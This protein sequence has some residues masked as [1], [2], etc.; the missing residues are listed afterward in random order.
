MK[1]CNFSGGKRTQLCVQM[2]TIDSACSTLAQTGS[3]KT[4]QC[5]KLSIC[6][7]IKTHNSTGFISKAPEPSGKLLGQVHLYMEVV[8]TCYSDAEIWVEPWTPHLIWQLLLHNSTR[9]SEQAWN[10]KS[11]AVQLQTSHRPLCMDG[12]ITFTHLK[13]PACTQD[14]SHGNKLLWRTNLQ[15]H[16]IYCCS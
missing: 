15:S 6:I 11:H 8:C 16:D 10:I 14:T 5:Q 4:F 3:R 9:V 12:Q 13:A 1:P 7:Q 2:C